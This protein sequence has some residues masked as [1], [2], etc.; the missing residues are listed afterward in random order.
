MLDLKIF[1]FGLNT[2][3]MFT[4]S[5]CQY[6]T[7]YDVGKG[8]FNTPENEVFIYTQMIHIPIITSL[9]TKPHIIESKKKSKNP[10][11]ILPIIER[12]MKDVIIRVEEKLPDIHPIVGR[13]QLEDLIL[14]KGKL[15][16]TK[17]NLYDNPQL[18][19]GQDS[20]TDIFSKNHLSV[21]PDTPEFLQHDIRPIS[22][23]RRTKRMASIMW[24]AMAL[25]TVVGSLSV[26]NRIDISSL[27]NQ[28]QTIY[29]NQREIKLNLDNIVETTNK[30]IGNQ[31]KMTYVINNITQKLNWMIEDYNCLLYTY[32]QEMNF[33]NN[34]AA[35]T[36][37]SF[38]RAVN[39]A[40]QGV[41]TLDLLP[42]DQIQKI[43]QYYS[44]FANTI[45]EDKPELLYQAARVYIVKLEK[46]PP[47]LECI[48]GVPKIMKIPFGIKYTQKSCHWQYKNMYVSIPKDID[49]IY[50]Y[51]EK[52]WFPTEGCSSKDELTLCDIRKF[53]QIQ[54]PCLVT[55]NNA[56]LSRCKLTISK[57]LIPDEAIQFKSGVLICNST[58]QIVSFKRDNYGVLQ[59]KTVK[60]NTSLYVDSNSA[61]SLVVG[62]E[63]FDL[64]YTSDV[65]KITNSYIIHNKINDTETP[66]ADFVMDETFDHVSYL[67][68]MKDLESI[69]T[70]H[71]I[72]AYA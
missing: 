32:D 7:Y 34:W 22:N 39:G 19:I 16:V 61:D 14:N 13:P 17:S 51:S 45:Y 60:V 64:S 20:S 18:K 50:S 25:G 47:I 12:R 42:G 23:T 21:E 67:P 8:I 31:E 58:K 1:I 38:L 52:T 29:D 44:S 46:N 68:K 37:N 35:L 59:S 33:I 30:L 43:I 48:I 71:H 54:D 69:N 55:D 53:K 11:N 9:P 62:N 66:I 6:P 26:Y 49:S 56:N 28:V 24:G 2:M 65:I 63:H 4:I 5:D 10:C 70:N 27:N 41:L 36:P 72:I 57:E 15:N 3:L 40:L